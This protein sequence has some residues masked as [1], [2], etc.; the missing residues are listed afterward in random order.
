MSIGATVR[1]MFGRHERLVADLWRSAFIDLDDF[2][3]RVRAWVPA[4]RRILEIG[5]GEGAGTERLAA[6]YPAASILA[7]DIAANLGRLYRGRT[8]KV[9]F[10]QIPISDVAKTDE[11]AF[12]LV[13]M[14]DVL[15]HIPVDMRSEIITA[16][17]TLLAPGGSFVCKDWARTPTPIHWLGYAADRWLTGDRISYPTRS[18]AEALFSRIFG[19][20]AVHGRATISPWRN[21]FALLLRPGA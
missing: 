13:V 4:P 5:C 9:T 21:N 20:S 15:H 16:A 14:C 18:E 19:A 2:F 17:R 11:G 3:D 6:I 10:R 8:N 12:D 1:R 7:I